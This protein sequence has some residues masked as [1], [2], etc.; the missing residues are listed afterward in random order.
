MTND[1][2]AHPKLLSPEIQ[3]NQVRSGAILS[4]DPIPT[5]NLLHGF[6]SDSKQIIEDSDLDPV[7]ISIMHPHPIP[8]PSSEFLLF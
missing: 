5:W 1:V 2:E 7:P 8:P 4:L 6:G 3:T